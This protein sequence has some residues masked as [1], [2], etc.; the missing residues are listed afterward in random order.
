MT[1][2]VA[3]TV[4]ALAPWQASRSTAAQRAT[5]AMIERTTC[6]A[7]L[8]RAGSARSQRVDHG[9]VYLAA[10]DRLRCTSRSGSID[11]RT[12]AETRS[13][14]WKDGVYTVQ[15][16]DPG[17]ATAGSP[18][19][20]SAD[21]D[22]EKKRRAHIAAV[23]AALRHHGRS[24]APRG[25]GTPVRIIYPPLAGL[26]WPEQFVIRWRPELSSGKAAVS[27]WV[28]GAASPLWSATT[29][30]KLGVLDSKAA[31]DALATAG[32]GAAG[33]ATF[34]FQ[35]ADDRGVTAA[36]FRALSADAARMLTADLAVW[37]SEQSPLLKSLGRAR[38]FDAHQ[39]FWEAGREYDAAYALTGS[40]DMLNESL[41]AHQRAA[42]EA[43][44]RVLSG[45]RAKFPGGCVDRY[46]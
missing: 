37:E 46:R 31:R 6:D 25:S 36:P 4:L 39:L 9:G 27:V 33:S 3:L 24:A 29:D 21:A 30:G 28:T 13:V 19:Q 44:V 35:F 41:A 12:G 11:I 15:S 20:R 42:D 32:A 26:V 16:A 34:I 38:A 10:G 43:Q 40:C 17:R 14:T 1:R 23:D 5:I 45:L 2:I 18:A 22:A 7:T 8:E